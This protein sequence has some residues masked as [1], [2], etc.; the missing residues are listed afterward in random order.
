MAPR[1]SGAILPIGTGSHEG[2]IMR[3]AYRLVA[4]MMPLASAA[5]LAAAV[6]M[7]PEDAARQS[8][9]RLC[10][11]HWHKITKHNV[12]IKPAMIASHTRVW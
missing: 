10:A 9:E 7:A 11:L 1:R 3:L 5:S 6:E 4:A 2:K 12:P 8:A